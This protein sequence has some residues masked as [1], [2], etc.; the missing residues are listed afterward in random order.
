MGLV[1][2]PSCGLLGLSWPGAIPFSTSSL[3]TLLF[4]VCAPATAP[5]MPCSFKAPCLYTSYCLPLLLGKCYFPT[6]RHPRCILP[7]APGGSD[8]FCLCMSMPGQHSA[9]EV[10]TPRCNSACFPAQPHT[11]LK[12]SDRILLVSVCKPVPTAQWSWGQVC[13]D[14]NTPG[15]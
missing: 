6:R 4:S 7:W 13:G 5:T 10:T 15:F 11:V 1:L 14:T 12:N 8:P 2:K 3:D 9:T